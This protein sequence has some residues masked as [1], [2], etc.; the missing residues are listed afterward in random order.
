MA[1]GCSLTQ[2]VWHAADAWRCL[3]LQGALDGGLDIPHSDKRF[4]GYSS[5]DKKLDAE[6]LK[7]HIYGGHVA[8]YMEEMM[9]EAPEKYQSHFSKWIA[10]EIEA[11]DIEDLYKGVRPFHAPFVLPISECLHAA[12]SWFMGARQP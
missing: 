10:A 9:E 5:E 4:V 3:W 7:K 6:V 1:W 12:K 2:H 11:E 8:E